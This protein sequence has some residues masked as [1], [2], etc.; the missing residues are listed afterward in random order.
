MNEKEHLVQAI[1]EH[2]WDEVGRLSS[3]LIRAESEH[4]ELV[5]AELDYTRWLAETCEV[6]L[7]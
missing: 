2:A 1:G 4:R 5:L 6:S 7:G 3:E